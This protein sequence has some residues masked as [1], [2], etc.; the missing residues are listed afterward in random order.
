MLSSIAAT[1]RGILHTPL[2]VCRTCKQ[3]RLIPVL[4]EEYGHFR[5]VVVFSIFRKFNSSCLYYA[6]TYDK[7]I[8][9]NKMIV[10][11]RINFRNEINKLFYISFLNNIFGETFTTKGYRLEALIAPMYAASCIGASYVCFKFIFCLSDFFQSIT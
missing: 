1:C 7:Q 11:K 10:R 8:M 6:Q 5:K 2:L 4:S 9:I 3:P